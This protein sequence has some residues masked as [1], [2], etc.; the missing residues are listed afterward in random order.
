MAA[1][2]VSSFLK[3]LGFQDDAVQ[4]P[5]MILRELIKNSIKYSKFTPAANEIA[6]RLQIDKNTY[7][8]EVSN[9]VDKACKVLL[10][11]LDKTIQFIRGYQ[12]P[13]EAY[14]IRLASVN[15]EANDLG[16]EKIAY[17][18]GIILD[19]YVSEDNFLNLSA[20]GSLNGHDIL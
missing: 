12:D 17:E 18:A 19:F 8:I 13:H 4:V 14:S 1:E 9:P 10:K 6:I 15:A 3:S 5:T 7:T 2:R 20:V 16:L 11:E